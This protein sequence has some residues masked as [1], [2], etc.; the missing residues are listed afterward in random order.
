MEPVK[1]LQFLESFLVLLTSLNQVQSNI[2]KP[3]T[4][5]YTE[6]LPFYPW[7]NCLSNLTTS[8]NNY[9]NTKVGIEH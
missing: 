6:E 2:K 5:L 7:K 4:K 1:N 8:R 9:K 3:L